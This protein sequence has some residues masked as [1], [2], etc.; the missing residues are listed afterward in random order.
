MDLYEMSYLYVKLDC[1]YQEE[2]VREVE[3]NKTMDDK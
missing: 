3:N 2:K 1:K